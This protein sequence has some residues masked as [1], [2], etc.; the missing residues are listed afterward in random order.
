MNKSQLIDAAAD[1]ANMSKSDMADALDAITKTIT[2]QV[3]RGEKVALTGFGTFERRERAARTGRNPQTGEQ[4]KVKASKT[5]AFKAG[6]A[7]KDAV[8]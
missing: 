8:S 3:A 5:P 1:E 7:F 4:I 2:E 6:K